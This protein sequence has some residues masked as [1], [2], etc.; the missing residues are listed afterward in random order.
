MSLHLKSALILLLGILGPLLLA[1][2]FMTNPLLSM[3][4]GAVSLAVTIFL[5]FRVLKPLGDI[6]KG[7]EN[8]ASGNLNFR[9]DIRSH[10]ELEKVGESFNKLAETLKQSTEKLEQGKDLISAERNKLSAIVSSVIDGIIAVDLAKNVVLV[11]KAAQDM[12]GYTQQEMEGQPIDRLIRLYKDQEEIPAKTYCQIAFLQNSASRIFQSLTLVGKDGKKIKIN[13]ATSAAAGEVETNLGCILILHDLTYEGQLEQMRLD[14]VSMASHELKT[15]L[16]SI[17]GYLSVFIDE[18]KQT[19]KKEGLDLLDRSL[20]S[21]KQLLTLI[22]NILSVN[23]IEREQMNFTIEPIDLNSV[24]SKAIDDLQNQAK[25]KNIILSFTKQDSLPKVLADA[26]R[27]T[28]VIDNLV[29]NALNYTDAGGRV[30]VSTQVTPNEVIVTVEDS[31]VGIPQEA[32]PH[33][34]NKFFRVS[35]SLQKANKG[36]G[37]GL[38]ISKSIIQSLHGKIWVESEVGKGSKFHFS[39]PIAKE[40]NLG[41]LDRSRLVASAIQSGS[42]NY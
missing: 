7:A 13:L 10:D 14:F 12:V 29:A 31:G 2:F 8:L 32:I 40:T 4:L 23:K 27:L 6:V 3:T 26:V 38:Y 34:F 21:A 18:N 16:T 17:I 20:V 9:L 37:L 1:I 39:L 24:F 11:N 25:L 28:E 15:P 30:I 41:T 22:G 5:L 35:N 33:L 42:L 36:S 19:L